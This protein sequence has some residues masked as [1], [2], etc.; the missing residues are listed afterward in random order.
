MHRGVVQ[1]D[2]NFSNSPIKPHPVYSQTTY[3]SGTQETAFP[4]MQV[5]LSFVFLRQA[6]CT[7]V[8]VMKKKKPI[9]ARVCH[10]YHLLSAVFI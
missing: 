4:W 3:D 2:G 6:S 7:C 9:N 5:G 10:V 1:C 8:I